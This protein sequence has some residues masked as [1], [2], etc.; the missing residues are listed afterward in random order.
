MKVKV[1]QNSI[2]L[3]WRVLQ[4]SLDAGLEPGNIQAEGMIAAMKEVDRRFEA[5]EYYMPSDASRAVSLAQ[6]LVAGGKSGERNRKNF[7]K[8]L[9]RLKLL[10]VPYN[11]IDGCS[12]FKQ[13]RKRG[14]L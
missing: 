14:M 12:H 9:K 10:V 6:S 3:I 5:G 1:F 13:E 2:M 8:R 7:F 4:N 11:S